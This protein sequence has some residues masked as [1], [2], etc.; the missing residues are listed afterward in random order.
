MASSTIS[1][2]ALVTLQELNPSSPYFKQ[3]ASLRATGK[4][5]DYN[6]EAGIATLVDGNATLKI[7][8]QHLHLNLRVGSL[9]QFI[10]E[11]FFEPS[12]EAVL[13]ARVG[14]NVDGMGLKLY[15]QSLQLLRE[16]QAEQINGRTP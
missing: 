12:N 5:Q 11:L 8:T 15:H 6:V 1:S 2:G 13:K 16:F 7:D 9:Y 14:R 4:L 10:G 3:G